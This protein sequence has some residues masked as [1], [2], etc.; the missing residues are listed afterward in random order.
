MVL[1]YIKGGPATVHS[2]TD[3]S[4]AGWTR[5]LGYSDGR[6]VRYTRK[7]GAGVDQV[8]YIRFMTASDYDDT[9]NA[10][11]DRMMHALQGRLSVDELISSM[12]GNSSVGV[13]LMKE[14]LRTATPDLVV[15]LVVM[16]SG[17]TTLMPSQHIR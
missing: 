15:K 5:G 10:V 3:K 12:Q 13:V 4:G 6:D 7:G 17:A 9:L 8:F 16:L 14:F 11:F 2:L 1:S